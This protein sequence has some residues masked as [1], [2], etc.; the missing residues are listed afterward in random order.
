M[1]L[2]TQGKGQVR[3]VSVLLCS[4]LKKLNIVGGCMPVAKGQVRAVPVLLCSPEASGGSHS[5]VQGKLE[6]FGQHTSVPST[7]SRSSQAVVADDVVDV[8]HCVADVGVVSGD[9]DG[10]RI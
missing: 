10:A 5:C 4:I 2:C 8:P 3:A 7:V 6:L 1:C 9:G